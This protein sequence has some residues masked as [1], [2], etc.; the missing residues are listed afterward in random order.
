[1]TDTG[2]ATGPGTPKEES[3]ATKVSLHRLLSTE[4]VAEILAVTPKTV[5]RWI[6]SGDLPAVKV[7][8]QWR[9]RADELERFL[10]GGTD[11]A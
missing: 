5:R 10:T 8:R 11:A 7:H 3:V 1:V 6:A 2:P 4:E 9:V